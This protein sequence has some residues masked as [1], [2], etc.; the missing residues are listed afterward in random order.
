MQAP[1]RLSLKEAYAAVKLN[2][3]EVNPLTD[4]RTELATFEVATLGTASVSVD[5]WMKM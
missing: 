4:N 5:E 1:H 3:P 2:R